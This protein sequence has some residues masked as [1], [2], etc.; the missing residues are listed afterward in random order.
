ALRQPGIE[1]RTAGPCSRTL[2]GSVRGATMNYRVVC[3][4]RAAGAG[5]E[6]GGRLVAERL[7]FH[8]FDDE[9]ISLASEQAGLDPAIIASAEHESSLLTRLLDA[10][11]R[12]PMKV[13]NYL[14]SRD[15]SEYYSA[16]EVSPSV[17]LPKE[18][19][20]RLIQAAIVEIA[21]RGNAVIV[22]H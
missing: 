4:S 11:V 2:A 21:R 16:D 20:R 17:Q 18:E 15:S 6:Q 22:A 9:V 10:L 14:K 12:P 3:V 8:Y 7:G 5:G 1:V 19:L 13:E